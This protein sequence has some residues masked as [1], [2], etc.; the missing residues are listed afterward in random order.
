MTHEEPS[1][2]AATAPDAA[3]L[4]DAAAAVIQATTRVEAAT[5]AR[6]D[7]I[8]AALAGGMPPVDVA[9]ATGLTPSRIREIASRRR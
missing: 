6:D 2:C 3:G 1:P 9:A 8:R 5:W 4:S 7:A